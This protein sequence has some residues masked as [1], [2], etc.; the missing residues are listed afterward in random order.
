M[1]SLL[2]EAAAGLAVVDTL[3]SESALENY[4][5][6]PTVRGDL[7]E[8]LGRLDEAGREFRRAAKLTRNAREQA[9]LRTRADACSGAGAL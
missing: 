1:L 4:H 7:L 9:L 2:G 8:K 3:V 5:L 6:L